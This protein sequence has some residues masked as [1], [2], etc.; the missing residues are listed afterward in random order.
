MASNATQECIFP[1]VIDALGESDIE[2]DGCIADEDPEFAGK[3]WCSTNVHDYNKVHISGGGFWGH[4]GKNCYIEHKSKG[5]LN[6]Y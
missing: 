6:L 3:F 2:H 4:C 1:F 5:E